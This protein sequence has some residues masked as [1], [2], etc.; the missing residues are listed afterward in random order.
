MAKAREKIEE[1]ARRLYKE[2]NI[3]FVVIIKLMEDLETILL[4]NVKEKKIKM[5]QYIIIM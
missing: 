5:M 2:K 4:W 1:V 3:K